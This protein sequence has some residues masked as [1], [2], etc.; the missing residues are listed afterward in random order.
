MLTYTET[1]DLL[2]QGYTHIPIIKKVHS[3]QTPTDIYLKLAQE[4]MSYLLESGSPDEEWGR[5]SFIGA[6]C[7]QSIQVRDC[8]V[9]LYQNGSAKA[10]TVDDP[11]LWIEDYSKT[12][13]VPDVEGVPRFIGGFVGYFGYETITYIEPKIAAYSLPDHLD[14]PDI[15]LLLSDKLAVFDNIS[16]TL[17]LIAYADASGEKAYREACDT[18][19]AMEALLDEEC[20]VLS[21]AQ[22]VPSEDD[23]VSEFGQQEYMDSV[24]VC[25]RYIAE[26]EAMQIVLSQ[27]MHAPFDCSAFHFYRALHRLNPSPYMYHLDFDDFQVVGSSPEILVRL[28]GDQLTLRPMAGTR[29]RGD[30][31][32]EDLALEKE[33]LS[34]SKELAEH[35]MLIDLGRNDLGR[36]AEVGSV[37]VTEKMTVERYSHVMHIVSHVIGKRCENVGLLEVLRATFPAGTVSGAPKVRAM[38]IIARLEPSKRNIY[39]GAVGYLAWD[40]TID[41]AIAIRTA[42]I[43]DKTIFVQTGAGLV[44]DSRPNHEWM[45]T[46]NKAR[47][48]FKAAEMAGEI[49][50]EPRS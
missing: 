44:Y 45:E 32:A 46:M 42:V 1:Q 31:E 41:L 50:R 26:G 49:S 10:F 20:P 22:S 5:Y 39:A 33:L 18:V 2:A 48:L 14:T 40:G 21:H 38:E 17:F 34:D 4:K 19:H 8:E 47:G 27:R 30:T 37:E 11:L 23:F 6:G 9:T 29:R 43:K 3:G 28:D 35:L 24:E 25:R 12:F 36:I 7:Q 15:F 16:N 13:R